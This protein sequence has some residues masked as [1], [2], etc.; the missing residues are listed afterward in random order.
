MSDEHRARI[1]VA[2]LMGGRSGEHDVSRGSGW[3]VLGQLPADRFEAFAV[4]IGRDGRWYF[5]SRSEADPARGDPGGGGLALPE[6]LR[7]LLDREPEVA[8]IAMHGPE[9]ED[10]RLQSLFELADLPYTGSDADASSLAM[11]KPVTKAV[12][13]DCGI[14]V[15]DDLLVPRA[16]WEADPVAVL[17][18]IRKRFSPP[19]V[20]KTPRLGSSVG[21]DIVPE[22]GDLEATVER[23]MVLDRQLLVEQHVAGRELTAAVLDAPAFGSMRALPV[24]EV[25]PVESAFFDYHAKYTVGAAREVCPAP[26][27]EGVRDRVQQLGL[28]AHRALGC[29]GFSRTDFIWTP[30]D[31][32]VTLET[33]TIPGLTRTSLV[34]QQ[35]AAAGISFPQLV[36]GMVLGALGRA[37]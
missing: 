25:T 28:Q 20:L 34:P 21:L 26:I 29:R 11:N 5:P 4:V 15:A 3:A 7:A 1:R 35:A 27:P 23:L 18:R 12:Y 33:N 17:G 8:F 16:D 6:G 9:G 2:V 14:P 10:G 37:A 13:R 22:G 19:W 30:G 31:E 36:S 32:L 24:L